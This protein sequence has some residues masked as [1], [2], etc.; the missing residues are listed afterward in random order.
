[1][2]DVVQV[3]VVSVDA[4]CAPARIGGKLFKGVGHEALGGS[5]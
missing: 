2:P 4:G 1:M 3:M 5:R